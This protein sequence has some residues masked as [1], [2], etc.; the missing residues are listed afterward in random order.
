MLAIRLF[1][2][3]LVVG[4]SAD[5][6]LAGQ[7]L[8][9]LGSGSLSER[10]NSGTDVSEYELALQISKD[11]GDVYYHWFFIDEQGQR[12]TRNCLALREYFGGA[13]EVF[14][15]ESWQSCS[16]TSSYRSAGWGQSITDGEHHE[17]FISYL[18]VNNGWFSVSIRK[19][20]AGGGLQVVGNYLRDS[21]FTRSWID[22][23]QLV[24]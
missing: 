14:I 1:I 16:D 23:M 8:D 6:L 21:S 24:Q 12:N 13:V 17:F 2:V 9:F 22:R 5:R 18:D 3:L 4:L 20:S 10:S 11:R 7:V 19:Y 15:P